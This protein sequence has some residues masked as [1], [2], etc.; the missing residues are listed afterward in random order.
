MA[1]NLK[2]ISLLSHSLSDLQVVRSKDALYQ[3]PVAVVDSEAYWEWTAPKDL[4]SAD[5]LA[6]N[7]IKASQQRTT[8]DTQQQQQQNSSSDDYWAE[9][10][11]CCV[12][13]AAPHQPQENI[14]SIS[15][16]A[17]ASHSVIDADCYWS[18]AAAP[19]YHHAVV[20]ECEDDYWSE[21]VHVQSDSDS[22]WA[23]GESSAKYW[24][25]NAAEPTASDRY[26]SM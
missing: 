1:P 3:S 13:V 9:E 4:F 20:V 6:G 21:A 12:A 24:R 23:E 5:H 17:E 2:R 22:Y 16:F 14:D 19:A 10:S 8:A 15:Y 11:S 18:E 25:W 7:L 26:W